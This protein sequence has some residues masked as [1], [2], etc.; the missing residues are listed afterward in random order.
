MDIFLALLPLLTEIGKFINAEKR[1]E[2]QDRVFKL[3][4]AYN[5]EIAKG[6]LRDDAAIYSIRSE[7]C[8]IVQ[9]YSAE[10]KGSSL[11]NSSPSGG[12]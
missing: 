3:E 10:L 6:S 5:E 4:K 8:L 1:T 7:L 12:N 11:A 9:L 2:Y